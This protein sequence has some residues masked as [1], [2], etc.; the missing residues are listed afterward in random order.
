MITTALTTNDF[1]NASYSKLMKSMLLAWYVTLIQEFKKRFII[2][3]FA[4]IIKL[5]LVTVLLPITIFILPV[6][7]FYFKLNIKKGIV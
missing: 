4:F 2:G 7:I 5:L 6:I 1:L 3:F